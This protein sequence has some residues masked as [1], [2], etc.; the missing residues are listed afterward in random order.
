[1]S[2]TFQ[3]FEIILAD[4]CSKDKSQ[5]VMKNL[6]SNKISHKILL[7]ENIGFCDIAN[8]AI[9]KATGKYVHLIATDDIVEKSFLQ[10]EFDFLENNSEYDCVFS[11][12]SVIDE[13]SKFLE[14]KTRRFDKYFL[15]KNYNTAQFLNHFFYKGNFLSAPTFMVKT[16]IL[17]EI[18]GFDSRFA[19]IQ[20]FDLW[21]RLCVKDCK[22][23]IL[24]ERLLRYRRMGDNN[25]SSNTDLTRIRSVF[26]NEKILNRYLEIKNVDFS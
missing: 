18:G 13:S 24:P 15:H 20:D 3:D 4:D 1:M 2:Q 8:L 6:E 16:E 22:I 17:K 10:K 5:E 9:S 23:H 19:Q 25:L 21:V 14:K 26:D 11:K 12:I 7:Q